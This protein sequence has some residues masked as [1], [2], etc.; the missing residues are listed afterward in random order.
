MWLALRERGDGSD[1][2]RYRIGCWNLTVISANTR[3]SGCRPKKAQNDPRAESYRVDVDS[4]EPL[5]Y[6]DTSGNW[7]RRCN[8]LLPLKD[9][10]MCVLRRASSGRSLGLIRPRQ[11]TSLEITPTST[12]WESDQMAAL[13][14]QG[15]WDAR[16]KVLEKI[17]FDFSY[18]FFCEDEG[19]RGHRMKV[20][21]WELCQSYRRWRRQYGERR[22]EQKFRE[23]YEVW[24]EGRDLHFFVGTMMG[25]PG[26]WI[27][28]G[29]F[30]PP[31]Q[32]TIQLALQ[33]TDF[34]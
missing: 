29:L 7:A 15:F 6:V 22:W 8:L 4:I 19:C 33:M 26:T 27:I 23:K 2:I 24:M 1:C 20:V 14:Q 13:A 25:Y 11:I 16:D 3:G 12:E 30:Y 5:S 10:S 18:R 9:P 17:P 21:D 28:V 31:K 34:Q 32:G